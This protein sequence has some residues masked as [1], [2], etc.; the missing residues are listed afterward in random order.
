MTARLFALHKL[1]ARIVQSLYGSHCE[2]V[3]RIAEQSDGRAATAEQG[4]PLG[5]E[6]AETGTQF[7]DLVEVQY[8][9]G[10]KKGH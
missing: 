10:Q 8:V 3:D 4:E 7:V 6:R 1:V 5:G 9:C 2:H